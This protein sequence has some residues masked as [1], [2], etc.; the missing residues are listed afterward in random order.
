MAAQAEHM[1][2]QSTVLQEF[3]RLNQLMQ[4]VIDTA[5]APAM[6]E[7][8]RQYKLLVEI[9]ST[10]LVQYVRQQ[11][12]AQTADGINPVAAMLV[13]F[14]MLTGDAMQCIPLHQ[15]RALIDRAKLDPRLKDMLHMMANEAPYRPRGPLLADLISLRPQRKPDAP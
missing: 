5:D 8:W 11:M 1:K 7:R 12:H 9:E 13:D 4:Q 3:E 6:R 10:Q 14:L 2:A 15:R